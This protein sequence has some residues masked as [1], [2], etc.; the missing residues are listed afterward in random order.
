VLEKLNLKNN[1]KECVKYVWFSMEHKHTKDAVLPVISI[2]LLI[3]KITELEK[4]RNQCQTFIN[5]E[6]LYFTMSKRDN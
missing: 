3:K 2:L 5:I 6:D 1:K 4:R